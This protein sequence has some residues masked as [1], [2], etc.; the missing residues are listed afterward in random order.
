MTNGVVIMMCGSAG[1]NIHENS[2]GAHFSNPISIP[3]PI[4]T[5]DSAS[6]IIVANSTI[7][8]VLILFSISSLA[9]HDAIT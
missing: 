8:A 4:I 3:K 9:I 1:I 7:F 5:A 6:G 2:S